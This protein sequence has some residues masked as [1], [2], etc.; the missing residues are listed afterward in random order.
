MKIPKTFI[1][2]KTYLKTKT[3]ILRTQTLFFILEL[4]RDH[5]EVPQNQDLGLSLH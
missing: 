1:K 2:T 3:L 4:P 5:A